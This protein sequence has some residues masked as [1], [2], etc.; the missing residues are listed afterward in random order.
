MFGATFYRN[1]AESR[2]TIPT[3]PE[4]M[5]RGVPAPVR[6]LCT[7]SVFFLH[8]EQAATIMEGNPCT[9]SQP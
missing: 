2:G 8:L 4:P 5:N 3:P 7:A 6:E 9:E 1:P